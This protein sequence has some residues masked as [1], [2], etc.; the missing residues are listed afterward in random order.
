MADVSKHATAHADRE[1]YGTDKK[2]GVAADM[3]D[4]EA[5]NAM[6]AKFVEKS[7]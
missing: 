6:V 4:L 1:L 2:A 5:M 3:P 7:G